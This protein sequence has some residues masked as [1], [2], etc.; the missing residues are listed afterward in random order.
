[1]C[2]SDHTGLYTVPALVFGVAWLAL[3]LASVPKREAARRAG[4]FA[5]GVL[6]PWLVASLWF[7]AHGAFG[8][9]ADSVFVYQRHWIAMIDPP[10]TDVLDQFV[11][12]AGLELAPLLVAAAVGIAVAWRRD[13]ARAICLLAWIG[14]SALAVIAQRQLAGYHFLL[15]V[16]GLAFAASYGVLALVDLVIHR[17]QLAR[18]GAAAGL[19]AIA[20]LLLGTAR[21]WSRAYGDDRFD[22]EQFSPAEQHTIASYL[23]AHTQPAQGI[24]VWALAPGIY[25][26]ADRHPTT[27]FPFHRLLLTDAPLALAVPG[28]DARRAEFL[29]GLRADPPAYIVLGLHDANPFE[30]QDSVTSLYAFRELSEIVQRDY[31]EEMRDAHFVVLARTR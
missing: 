21:D 7:A 28:R 6:A 15:L 5:L 29:A 11:S 17:A 31:H 4:W 1:V 10:W 24:L 8:V 12:I 16:P 23:A 27:R 19:V 3:W 30:P 20:A 13:R 26:L 22:R 2:Y 18:V 14:A 9:F 25:A